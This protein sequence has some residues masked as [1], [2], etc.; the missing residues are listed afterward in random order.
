MM[1][2]QI[3]RSMILSLKWSLNLKPL[4]TCSISSSNSN[5]I[6]MPGG[7]LAFRSIRDRIMDMLLKA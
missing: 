7:M 3:A 6:V 4:A 1:H 2:T 5:T